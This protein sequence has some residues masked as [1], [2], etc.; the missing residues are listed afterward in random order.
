[1]FDALNRLPE[2]QHG[3]DIMR[4][5]PAYLAGRGRNVRQTVLLASFASAELNA[6]ARRC[7]N[8]AGAARLVPTYKARRCRGRAAHSGG[9]QRAEAA[10]GAVHALGRPPYVGGAE[11]AQR[12][13]HAEAP[14]CDTAKR[15]E[16]W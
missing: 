7:A 9:S 3:A 15:P 11:P 4:V 13:L 10:G 5:R 8:V 1:V 6:L 16:R 2:A 12:P 14:S